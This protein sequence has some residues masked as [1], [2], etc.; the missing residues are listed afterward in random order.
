MSTLIHNIPILVCYLKTMAVI[1][2]NPI[3]N[4]LADL[5][6]IENTFRSLANTIL[7]LEIKKKELSAQLI[8]L[9][10]VMNQYQ[11]TIDNKK[12][13]LSRMNVCMS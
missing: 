8:D 6:S 12:E 4:Y 5:P 2:P 9:K 10:H 7:D 1:T 3:P 13:Q 11:S